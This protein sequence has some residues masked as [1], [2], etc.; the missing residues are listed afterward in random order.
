[1]SEEKKDE[2][3]ETGKTAET[4]AEN[5]AGAGDHREDSQTAPDAGGSADAAPVA[6]KTNRSELID[7]VTRDQLRKTDLD[8]TVGDTVEVGY[9]IREGNKERIQKFKGTV[10]AVKHGGA[11]KTFTV[12]RI[13]A[14]EGVERIFPFSSPF[15]EA[16]EV[17]RRGKNRRGKLYYLRGR[18]GKATK[19][20]EQY[21]ALKKEE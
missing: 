12:R 9:R 2:V 15:V 6:R 20:K 7:A 16:V 17:T 8:F 19:V 21:L 3:L 4:A 13:V 5:G 11:D 10:I 1:M 18:K 14:G